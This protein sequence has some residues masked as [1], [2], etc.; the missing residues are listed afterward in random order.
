M[1]IARFQLPDGR[2][3]RFEVPA[4]TT[5]EQAQAMME[6]HFAQ[7][8]G[9]SKAAEQV[10]NDPITQAA[11][12]PAAEMS[13]LERFNAGMGA[14][15]TNIGRGAAQ[16]VGAGP[17]QAEM[18]DI[19]QRDKPLMSTG[20]GFA[21]N[22][23]GNIAAMAPLALVPG[24]NTVGG[25]ATLGAVMAGVQPGAP[26][27]KLGN[28]A[29]GFG[30]G[31]GMQA[32]AQ[33]P[34][35]I[36]EAGKAAVKAPFKV[37]RALLNTATEGGREKILSRV[38]QRAAGPN[39]ARARANM[40]N[41]PEF[42]PGSYPT[43]GEASGSAGIA[44][45]QRAAAA[46]D[47]EAYFA[48]AAAQNE[49]RVA[50]LQNVAGTHGEREFAKA[51]R[52]ATADDLYDLARKS[53][54]DLSLLSPARRGEI[55]KLMRTPA[56]RD[57][58]KE[59]RTLA[60]NEMQKVGDP[61][62]SVRG[63]D[64]LQRALADKISRAT[65]NEQ[66]IL[67]GLRDRLLTTIDTLSPEFQTARTT[68]AQ[69]SKPVT[70]MEIAQAIADKAIRPID[71]TIMPSQLA[72]ALRDQTAQSVTGMRNATLE[73]TMT[74][75]KLQE[76]RNVLADVQRSSFLANAGRGPG[77]DTVQKLAMTNMMQE[78]GLPMGV[79]RGTPGLQW[80]SKLLFEGADDAMRA[81]LA[82][83]LLD[84][85]ETARIMGQAPPVYRPLQELPQAT[86]DRLSALA[87]A[88]ALPAAIQAEQ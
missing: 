14:G 36:Y 11:M 42:V 75:Q 38:L 70:E 54:L 29:L 59:A 34:V 79:I 27:E 10:L 64:Y 83:A 24:A 16:L 74:P 69:M 67:V 46:T 87:R 37:G 31:G 9:R 23:A 63:L 77:S 13:Q 78:S 32:A 26:L 66:R 5:P 73:S 49:A 15:M 86:R 35:G 53:G 51:A 28:M 57:A 22:V 82:Q 40:Q 55:T 3:A 7:Q 18:A 68:F 33:N 45:L 80:A 4:G 19:N 50:A 84:P 25:A 58:V 81:K 30:L 56:I 60:A 62:G 71:Q 1:P 47:P 17:S 12:N 44:S 39:A 8:P 43:A 21:G 20:A 41:P 2:V 6:Q 65:G 85:R 88:L 48:R 76:L 72:K 52:A 61:A